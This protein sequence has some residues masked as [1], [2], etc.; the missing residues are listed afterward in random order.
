MAKHMTRAQYEARTQRL[1]MIGVIVVAAL[2]VLVIGYGA[3]NELVLKPNR[4]LVEVGEDKITLASFEDHVR[5]D[6]YLQT[7][8][9]SPEELSAYAGFGFDPAQYYPET[10][11]ENALT[12]LINDT[13]VRQK[14]AEMGITVTEDEVRESL[15]LDF[16][17]DAGEPEPTPTASNTPVPTASPTLTATFVYTTTPFPTM[18]L[19]PDVTVTPT[20]EPSPT[21]PTED[22]EPTET[23]T[24]RPTA[25][26]VTEEGFQ[27][28]YDNL[29]TQVA[30]G[31]GL[32]EAR[33]RE[34]WY[35][36]VRDGLLRERLYEALK[37]EYEVT[38]TKEKIHVA[39]ILVLTQEE[40]N[41]L[42][43]QIAD[44]Q[45]FEVLAADFSL[46]SSNAYRGGDLGWSSPG[47]FVP[48][49]EEAA[50][51]LEPG[52]I[53]A[54]V[55]TD[56]GWHIIKMYDRETVDT[57]EGEREGERQAQFTSQVAEWRNELVPDVGDEWRRYVPATLP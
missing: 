25:T 39:H 1:V 2:V 51:A 41:D 3:L 52:E 53:S 10:F 22:L 26:Q 24:P 19:A 9:L 56:F 32:S 6:Y 13:I 12:S 46:D 50:Y 36:E 57:T 27:A 18:T 8:G 29:I 37:D 49:F 44:G 5:F 15:E 34:L 11:A 54:P 40:A 55:L 4:T 42:A 7:G 38:Q 16:G 33:V 17:F 45:E 20:L 28:Q 14:A 48:E 31:T 43:A 30:D 23:P 35:E 47:Q 21:I